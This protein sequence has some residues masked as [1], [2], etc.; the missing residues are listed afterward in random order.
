MRLAEQLILKEF[1]S[2]FDE[3]LNWA[4]DNKSLIPLEQKSDRKVYSV[5]ELTFTI[6][7]VLESRFDSIWVTGEI[8]GLRI[9]SSGHYYFTLKDEGAQIQCVLFKGVRG[10][11]RNKIADGRKVTLQG[12]LGLYAQRGHYQLI[13][14]EVQEDGVGKLAVEFEKLKQR[15]SAEGLFDEKRKKL[16]PI[17]PRKIGIV[18]SPTG[19]ALQDILRV[20]SRGDFD[21]GRLAVDVILAPSKVQGE[22]AAEDIVKGI[23]RLNRYH[24]LLEKESGK[25][26][27]LILVTRGGGSAEDLWC[28]NE[29]IVARAIAASELPVI[30][31]VGHEIDFSI[32]D[33]VADFRSPT[34]TAAAELIVRSILDVHKELL[35]SLR[36]MSTHISWQIRNAVDELRSLVR[37]L[38]LLS[39][40]RRVEDARIRLDDLQIVMQRLL[41][42]GIEMRS[43]ELRYIKDR[44]CVLRPQNN[45][46]RGWEE[47]EKLKQGLSNRWTEY[48][49]ENHQRLDMLRNTLLL[50]DPEA[51]LR[52]G[53]SITR[54]ATSGA[55][56]RNAA[57]VISG[58]K[59][60]TRVAEGE[61]YS[62][63]IE[64][65][66]E[67]GQTLVVN[68]DALLEKKAK[69][70][71]LK[72]SVQVRRKNSSKRQSDEQQLHLNL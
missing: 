69:S 48:L 4:E 72:K 34:P 38:R 32:S 20:L 11:E 7:G 62:G 16:L 59:L 21:Q 27:D 43:L 31:A 71:L 45:C 37:H 67:E 17:C 35:D 28:F 8:S 46:E 50:L 52:R 47:V 44:F 30:S 29:E 57:Q 54:D 70:H 14:R 63:V 5:S 2:M 1:Q 55:V 3:E 19:A 26:L 15:L 66:E 39:P 41:K 53:Y 22:G 65:S 12:D 51:N 64:F 40:Q 9:Q 36:K 60:V 18:T 42:D 25:G 10:V 23:E 49:K 24:L 13:V 33:F 68:E 56:I 61:I 6:K 58:Q